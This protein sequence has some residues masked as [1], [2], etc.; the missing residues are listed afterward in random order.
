MIENIARRTIEQL[1]VGKIINEQRREVYEYALVI[2]IEKLITMLSLLIIGWLADA[3]IPTVLFVIFFFSLRERTGGLHAKKFSSCYL[4][5]IVFF[6]IF[7]W[8]SRSIALYSQT[9]CCITVASILLVWAIGTVNHPNMHM[10][11]SEL[12]G[13]KKLARCLVTREGI[14]IAL[15]RLMGAKQIYIEFM[16][17]AVIMCA[18]LLGSAKIL[19]Q[20]V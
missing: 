18:F 13:A 11:K 9:F 15:F 4:V 14:C 12:I 2:L 5:T 3:L 20:E 10:S 19:R 1:L 7:V 6:T 17:C 16:S 8:Y